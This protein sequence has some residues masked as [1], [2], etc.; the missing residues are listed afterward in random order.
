MR[1]FRFRLQRVLQVR[2]LE[3]QVARARWLHLER[4]AAVAEER[5]VDRFR[6]R[7]TAQRE[8]RA[9]LV[10]LDPAGVLWRHGVLDR[11]TGAAVRQ[12]ERAVTL[13]DRAEQRRSPWEDRRREVRALER[14]RARALEAHRDALLREETRALD[15]LNNARA[16]TRARPLRPDVVSRPS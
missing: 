7:D 12:R 10:G 3:E 16:H 13:R 5:A 15:E 11:M 2:A 8:L 6:A 1:P 4:E 14:L 9:T